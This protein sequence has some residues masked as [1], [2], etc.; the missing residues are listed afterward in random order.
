MHDS[1]SWALDVQVLSDV[2]IGGTPLGAGASAGADSDTAI[3]SSGVGGQSEEV[4]PQ[5]A[6]SIPLFTCNS[7]LVYS[8]AYDQPR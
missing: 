1:L 5:N 6:Q 2:L 3:T 8:A 7:D 4:K